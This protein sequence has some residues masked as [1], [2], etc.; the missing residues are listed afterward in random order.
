MPKNL[1]RLS[2]QISKYLAKYNNLRYTS[3]LVIELL[4]NVTSMSADVAARL[5]ATATYH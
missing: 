5:R 1:A 3:F 2:S 4:I